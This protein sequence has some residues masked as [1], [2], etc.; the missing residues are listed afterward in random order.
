[1]L[2]VLLFFFSMTSEFCLVSEL[3]I[4]YEMNDWVRYRFMLL[5]LL[6]CVM[7]IFRFQQNQTK[8][9]T[10]F[11]ISQSQIEFTS[12]SCF[13]ELWL[14]Y[15]RKKKRKCL[16][17][18][19]ADRKSEGS[20]KP[21]PFIYVSRER[22]YYTCGNFAYVGSEGKQTFFSCCARIYLIAS[23]IPLW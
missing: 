20:K 18:N 10:D 23:E 2:L 6:F 3:P 1:M 17:C 9:V 11:G 13:K 8:K 15:K 22:K 4:I 16:R 19:T 7:V 14:R 21:N 12:R 5:L